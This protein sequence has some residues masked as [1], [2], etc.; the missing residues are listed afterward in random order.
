MVPRRAQTPIAF[1]SDKAAARLKLLAA[2][3]RSQAEIM[4]DA[5]E[6]LPLPATSIVRD[7]V[8]ARRSRIE[9][10]IDRFAAAPGPSMAE[11]DRSEYDSAGNPR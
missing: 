4:E 5:L 10:I 3:G 6:R 2:D 7:E 1:R 9:A 8:A 11:F